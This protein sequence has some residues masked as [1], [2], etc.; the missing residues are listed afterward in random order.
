MRGLVVGFGSIGKRHLRN[1]RQILPDAEL[2]VVRHR[3]DAAPEP[4]LE[5]ANRVVYRLEDALDNSPEF[6]IICSPAPFHVPTALPLAQADVHLLIEKPISD[7]LEGIDDLL[8]ICRDR[9]LTLMVGYSLRFD[10]S[11]QLT[12]RAIGDGGIGR[13][14][15]F[16]SEVGQYL[17]DWRKSVPYRDT[18]TAQKQ[19]G[20]GVLLELSHE[21]DI[22]SWLI[23]DVT[24]V[25]ACV[26][27]VGDLGVDVEDWADLNL[28]FGCG[29]IGNIHLDMVQRSAVRGCRIVGTDGTVTW[30]ALTS[31]VR[32]YRA[33]THDWENLHDVSPAHRNDMYLEELRHFVDC[34][35][36]NDTPAVTGDDG[37]RALKIAIAA[38][39]SAQLRRSVEV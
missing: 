1:L 29:A 33:A 7:K 38:R 31:Q 23:G 39:K 9:N 26:S 32:R 4:E 30:D 28:C 5:L 36:N 13:V 16:R 27:Q 25:S 14:I 17:P 2:T 10:R 35:R 8:A 6:A 21:L 12:R 37:K 34:V 22:A 3:P 11:L 19:L 18:V 24:D 15:G 20:G